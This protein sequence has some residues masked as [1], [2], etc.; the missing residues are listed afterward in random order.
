LEVLKLYPLQQILVD[1]LLWFTGIC[2]TQEPPEQSGFIDREKFPQL[3][4]K[5]LDR[6]EL[7]RRIFPEGCEECHPPLGWEEGLLTSIFQKLG[8]LSVKSL[9]ALPH[10]CLPWY[11]FEFIIENEQGEAV[12]KLIGELNTNKS[13][14]WE[15]RVIRET[16]AFECKNRE[17]L[18][19]I[20]CQII[21][22]M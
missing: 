11:S 20:A 18:K 6:F 1:L 16:R 7:I 12:L 10:S 15:T 22:R 4:V 19:E 9:Y 14:I 3:S 17:V 21:K 13:T 5:E 2:D 8:R